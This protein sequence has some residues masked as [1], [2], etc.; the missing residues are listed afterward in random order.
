M[1][2]AV[3]Q[4]G[5]TP[6]MYNPIAAF[7]FSDTSPE[8]IVAA[9]GSVAF[10]RDRTGT[11]NN[12]TQSTGSVKPDTNTSTIGGLNAVYFNNGDYIDLGDVANSGSLTIITAFKP[13]SNSSGV[14]SLF[15]ADGA[16]DFQIDAGPSGQWMGRFNSTNLGAGSGIGIGGNFLGYT[17]VTTNRVSA[18][19][20]NIKNRLNGVH[21]NTDSYN[22]ALSSPLR[23]RI[24]ANRAVNTG[25]VMKVGEFLIFDTALTDAQMLTI[26]T[27]LMNKW[28]IS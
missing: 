19:D 12:A 26:E 3:A 24:G 11:G 7:D 13:I 20:G 27:Y 15:S 4:S 23:M 17:I 9:G 22:G 5:N 14:A 25:I 8:N 6:T 2:G 16:N 28:G 10:A 1:F 18:S 21:I